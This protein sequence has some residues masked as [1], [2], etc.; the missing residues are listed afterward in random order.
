MKVI[1]DT[2]VIVSAALRDKEPEAVVLFISQQPD[3]E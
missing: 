3:V 1:V 2:N